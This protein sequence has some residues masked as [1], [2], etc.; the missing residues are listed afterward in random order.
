MFA[1][2]ALLINCE[3][4][5]VALTPNDPATGAEGIRP[6]NSLNALLWYA[7]SPRLRSV[8]AKDFDEFGVVRFLE[9]NRTGFGE[10]GTIYKFAPSLQVTDIGVFNHSDRE[11]VDLV[12]AT[13]LAAVTRAYAKIIDEVNGIDLKDIV[14]SSGD[15]N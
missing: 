2:T 12:P 11:T 15:G 5:A 7:G 1:K 13:G 3:H 9:P 14:G 8:A 6:T 4:T 10:N